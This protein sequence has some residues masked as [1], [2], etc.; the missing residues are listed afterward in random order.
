MSRI[1]KQNCISIH[2]QRVSCEAVLE[3]SISKPVCMAWFLLGGFVCIPPFW[4]IS[5]KG[6]KSNYT[7]S[8][9]LYSVTGRRQRNSFCY[10]RCAIA[11]LSTWGGGGWRKPCVVM[12]TASLLLIC[13]IGCWTFF[14]KI[15]WGLAIVRHCGQKSIGEEGTKSALLH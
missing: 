4:S 7:A 2:K 10:S 11:F 14:P 1:H 8:G 12:A 9:W 6:C 13:V 15:S 3:I 5:L